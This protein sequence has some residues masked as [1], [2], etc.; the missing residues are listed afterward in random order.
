MEPK[1]VLRPGVPNDENRD[2]LP[3]A[4]KGSRMVV[5]EN[6]NNSQVY[7]QNLRE[8]SGDLLGDGITDTWYVYVPDSYDPAR[9]TPLV[10]SMHGGLMNGWGQCVYTSWSHV[11]DKEGF[12][13][14]F[15]NASSMGMWM[16]ECDPDTVDEICSPSYE[17]APAL[18]RPAGRVRDFH[19]VRLVLALLE[20]MKRE[21]NIDAGRVYIQ[22]M[23]MGNAMTSQVARYAGGYFAAAAGSGCPSNC[24]LLFTPDGGLINEGGPLDVWSSRLEHDRTPPHYGE[25]DRTVV[26][27]NLNYWR[28]LNDAMGLPEVSVRGDKN[29]LFYRGSIGNVVLMDVYNRDH[30]QTF[31]DAQMV[32]DYLFSGVY[33]DE[34]GKLCHTAPR[35]SFQKDEHALLLSEGASKALAGGCVT[36]L[37]GTCFRREKIKYHGLNG[38]HI[39]RGSYLYAPVAFLTEMFGGTLLRDGDRAEIRLADGRELTFAHGCIGCTID[40]CVEAM[41]CEA[42]TSKGKLYVPGGWFCSALYNWHVSDYGG[43]TYAAGHVSHLSRYA[44]WLLS[45]ILHGTQAQQRGM[46]P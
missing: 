12:L 34:T 27:G 25:D 29:L 38:K 39:V 33:R 20:K 10:F 14:V 46:K 21:Y 3:G 11:A 19:D 15:P 23:S 4:I 6:G 35:K 17:G 40:N 2:Y 13:C 7:P 42:I 30:G 1:I 44:A 22:G 9:K 36:E 24:K 32:W 5:N 28:R 41:D 16:I 45:D 26:T 43:C 37:G 31:D 8:Y 18:N